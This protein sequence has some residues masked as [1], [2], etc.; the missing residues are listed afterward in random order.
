VQG[1]LFYLLIFPH[2]KLSTIKHLACGFVG[3]TRHR[4]LRSNACPS[5][6]PGL[7]PPCIAF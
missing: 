2:A 1:P 5:L 4:A 6:P 3:K 7:A